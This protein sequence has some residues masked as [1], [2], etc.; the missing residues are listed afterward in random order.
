ME[1]MYFIFDGVKSSDM[2]LQIMRIDQ[3]DGFIETP[4]W[5]SANINEQTSGKKISP[6][7]YGVDREPISFLLQFVLVDEYMQPMEWTPQERFKIAK[8]LLH[9]TYKEFQTSDDLGKRYF[10]LAESQTDLHL[11]NTQG[12]IEIEFRTNSPYAWSP[13][14]IDNFDLSDNINTQII[15][16]ENKSNVLKHYNPIIEIELIGDATAIQL[17]NM[18]N[19]GKT[20]KFEGLDSGEIVSIDCENKIIKSSIFGSNPFSKFNVDGKRY[21]MDLVYGVNQI[22]ITG[23]CKVWIKSCFPIAQ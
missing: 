4:Y 2:G 3:G 12:Y 23:A 21:W 18:S 1:S 19:G 10:A 6:H 8:W 7:F 11:I 17:T 9:D 16:I 14:Y 5:G 22:E 15:E 20:M 13:V